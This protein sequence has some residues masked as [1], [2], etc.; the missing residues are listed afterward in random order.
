MTVVLIQE[1]KS[2]DPDVKTT[3]A[4]L[5]QFC[6]SFMNHYSL[7]DAWEPE[8]T[9]HMQDRSCTQCRTSRDHNIID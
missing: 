9:D 7:E 3:V 8:T 4:S 1:D 2:T 6:R 5:T